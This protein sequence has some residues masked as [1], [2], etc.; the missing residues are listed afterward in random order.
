MS[1][2]A[3]A[4]DVG[5]DPY[6]LEL[7]EQARQQSLA[8]DR[9]WLRLLHMQQTL[10]GGWHSDID[11]PLF[12]RSSKGREDPVA[13][14]DATLA[15]FFSS[16]AIA[17]EPSQ[18]RY[19]ARY[20]W[21]RSRL[22][23]DAARLKPQ[24]CEKLLRW[25]QALN[26]GSIAIV[27]AANDL[28]NPSS[29]FGHSLLRL[30]AADD[31][32]RERLLAYAVNYAAETSKDD[33]MTYAIK[34]LG[35][36]YRGYY[37]VMPYYD[38]I[39]EYQGYDHRDLWEYPLRLTDDQRRRLLWHLWEMR[40]IGS[41]YYFFTRN[42]S[43]Q[44]LTL[45]ETVRP[46]LSLTQ[47]FDAGIPYAIPIDTIRALRDAGLLEDPEFH[48][49]AARELQVAYDRLPEAQQGWVLDYARG[50][51]GLDDARLGAAKPEERARSLDVA[52][53][54]LYLL[55]QGGSIDRQTGLRRDH[56]L[57]LSRSRI[58]ITHDADIAIAPGLSPDR[59]HA[60][61]RLTVGAI[62]DEGEAAAAVHVRPAYHDRL[63]PPGGYLSGAEIEFL[64]LGALVR[65]GGVTLDQSTLISVQ[66]VGTRSD[67]WHPWSWQVSTGLRRFGVERFTA[68]GHGALGEYVDG[69][70]GL[71]WSPAAD[72]QLYAFVMTS[73]E[74]NHDL[75]KDYALQSGARLGWAWQP[76]P[77]VS[78]QLQADWM[79]DAAGGGHP[80]WQVGGQWQLHFGEGNG[81]RWGL[82]YGDDGKRQAGAVRL[83]WEH[84][85]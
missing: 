23:F 41:P 18:C 79:G 54:Y 55:F 65:K 70:P 8:S 42:C 5:S 85:F 63:D 75:P 31:T 56:D 30:N 22:A 49:S 52:H 61:G 44:L 2:G 84:Y 64:D 47:R 58:G 48:P 83:A 27:F 36:E 76:S 29:M 24:P 10:A 57:L 77:A 59:G 66:D 14:L 62:A 78:S 12:F 50:R 40:G 1:G 15:S 71:A 21:L 19:K 60:S 67:I 39:R 69:G 32:G 74:A 53:Q 9:Q 16:E 4:A 43:Y 26:V 72:M 7:Q 13:E 35:G 38:K 73:L 34:G 37:S 68:G 51:A 28:D 3:R 80:L 33:G 81:L 11:M 17:D 6:L 20:E 46:D 25:E 82:F 45:I